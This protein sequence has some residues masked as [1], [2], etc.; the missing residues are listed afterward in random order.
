MILRRSKLTNLGKN[1]AVWF[2]PSYGYH[3]GEQTRLVV[4][5]AAYRPHMVRLRKRLL[6]K[7]LRRAMRV[8]PE[9][10]DCEL[11][12][13]RIRP[14]IASPHRGRRLAVCFEGQIHALPGRSRRRRRKPEALT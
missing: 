2:F 10:L 5:G 6:V 3:D 14:F 4:T 9:E 8:A 12:R 7:L 13:R 11:F 1:T